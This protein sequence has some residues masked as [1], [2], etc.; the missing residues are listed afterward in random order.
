VKITVNKITVIPESISALK[1]LNFFSLDCMRA[2]EMSLAVYFAWS[3]I[4]RQRHHGDSRVDCCTHESATT[5][6][7]LYV[8]SQC[9][10]VTFADNKNIRVI[11]ASIFALENL[12]DLDL[13]GTFLEKK[14][15]VGAV[16]DSK[17]RRVMQVLNSK[18]LFEK[19]RSIDT[20][21]DS[22]RRR[23]NE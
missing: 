6:S 19:K 10:G 22:K 23:I 21:S 15:S 20:V 13:K 5:R 12:Q 11:P 8:I 4:Y 14:R 1:K 17:R 18:E 9:A 16:S 7:Q 3:E 2:H